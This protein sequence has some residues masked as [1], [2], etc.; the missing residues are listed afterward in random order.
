MDDGED[1]SG[2]DLLRRAEHGIIAVAD[3]SVIVAIVALHGRCIGADAFGVS[4][5]VVKRGE[6]SAG[7]D[8]EDGSVGE[9]AGEGGAIKIAVGAEGEAAVGPRA[10]GVVEAM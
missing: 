5:E 3:G 7:G 4:I 6:G 10:I 9:P 2:S 1:A 8:A